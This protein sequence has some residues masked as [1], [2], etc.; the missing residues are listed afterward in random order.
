MPIDLKTPDQ[1]TPSSSPIGDIKQN[2]D[3][4]KKDLIEQAKKNPQL[5]ELVEETQGFWSKYG[6]KIKLALVGIIVLIVV[7]LGVRL[8]SNLAGIF[9]PSSATPPEIPDITPT[10]ES[11]TQTELQNLKEEIKEFETLLPDPAPPPVDENIYLQI[12]PSKE[13]DN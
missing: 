4:Q 7:V 6:F 3:K 5:M 11:T 13:L 9:R 2:I 12:D 10:V 8:G 1:P